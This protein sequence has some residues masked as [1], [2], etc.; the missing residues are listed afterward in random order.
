MIFGPSLHGRWR[1][2]DLFSVTAPLMIRLPDGSREIMVER[3]RHPRGVL[4]FTP[5]W[6]LGDPAETVRLVEGDIKGEGPWKIGGAVVQVLG[7]HGSE[8]EC[9]AEF[10]SWRDYLMQA[11]E[12]ASAPSL[13]RAPRLDPISEEYPSREMIIRIAK[14][15]GAIA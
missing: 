3:F 7:C 14:A 2:P 15:R 8:P 13:A 9:A 11:G 5:F 12:D 10:D 6:H 4:Y 1:V